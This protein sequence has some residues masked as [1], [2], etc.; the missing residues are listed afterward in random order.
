MSVAAKKLTWDDIKDWPESAGRTEI[1]DGELVMSPPPATKHQRICTYL[2]FELVGF[3]RDH[4]LGEVLTSAMHV[5][6]DEHVHYEPDL[7]FIRADRAS[8]VGEVYISGPPDLVIEVISE[9]NR[10]HDT[11]VKFRDYAKY[12]VSEYWLVDPRDET[13]STWALD[14]D[15]YALLDRSGPGDAVVTR[16]LTGLRLDPGTLFEYARKGRAD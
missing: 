10:T 1:V 13:I 15:S 7:C 8:I 16:V 2:G 14:G 9:S 12:G 5:I 3:V 4:K 11:V 6:L